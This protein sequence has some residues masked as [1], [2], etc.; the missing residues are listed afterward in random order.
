MW[1]CVLVV[2]R[3]CPVSLHSV[4]RWF[5]GHCVGHSVISSEKR[6]FKSEIGSL[7]WLQKRSVSKWVNVSFVVSILLTWSVSVWLAD[8][9][10]L[11]NVSFISFLWFS[12]SVVWSTR[13]YG[14]IAVLG[15]LSGCQD[16]H[17]TQSRFVQS[18]VKY[19]EI[20]SSLRLVINLFEGHLWNRKH[21]C[22]I[23]RPG[24]PNTELSNYEAT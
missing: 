3:V 14:P 15:G 22:G 8:V 21:Q 17:Q 12:F 23:E 10:W 20:F 9:R 6:K 2:M 24:Y 5:L 7:L 1:K 4:E 18:P 19:S 16:L 11:S 13:I